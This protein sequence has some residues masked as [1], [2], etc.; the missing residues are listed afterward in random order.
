MLVR[1]LTPAECECISNVLVHAV[2]RVPETATVAATKS[3][4]AAL[5][6]KVCAHAGQ[7][8]VAQACV[9]TSARAAMCELSM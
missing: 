6:S 1:A 9:S 2:A 5:S 8:G 4:A 7:G 3:L